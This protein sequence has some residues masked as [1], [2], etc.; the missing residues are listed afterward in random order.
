MK[1][2]QFLTLRYLHDAITGEFANLGVV[3][4]VPGES[5]CPRH[6]SK[7]SPSMIEPDY[8]NAKPAP[9][10]LSRLTSAN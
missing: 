10:W 8:F 2:F 3:V 6:L 1:S 5:F 4:Y 7:R 9:V